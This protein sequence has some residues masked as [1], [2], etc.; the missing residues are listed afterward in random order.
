MSENHNQSF[1]ISIL[2][3]VIHTLEVVLE[4]N[5]CLELEDVYIYGMLHFNS[6]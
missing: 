6:A 1:R 4:M 5:K 3:Q 2:P